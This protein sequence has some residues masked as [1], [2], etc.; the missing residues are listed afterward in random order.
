[1]RDKSITLAG[2]GLAGS[3]L[4]VYLARRGFRVTVYE[5]RK[6]MRRANISEGR[7]IN[8]ALAAYGRCATSACT[9]R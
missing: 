7:S 3:L 5:R 2:A 9:R 8:L 6:D 1:M 4:A